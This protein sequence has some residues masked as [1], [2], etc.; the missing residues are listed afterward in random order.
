MTMHD[1]TSPP[2]I[3]SFCTV[4][5][6]LCVYMQAPADA[7]AGLVV[8]TGGT[9]YYISDHLTDIDDA[10]AAALSDGFSTGWLVR[11]SI[12]NDAFLDLTFLAAAATPSE[13]FGHGY[14]DPHYIIRSYSEL[15]DFAEHVKYRVSPSSGEAWQ[16]V[17]TTN[18]LD[19][20]AA[21]HWVLT[22]P[23]SVA[24]PEPNTFLCF[25]LVGLAFGGWRK[26]KSD[27]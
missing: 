14:V 24:V 4:A 6:M 12:E 13:V 15:T 19:S 10:A 7:L 18:F 17:R 27:S 5:V 1:L 2:L 9:D 21:G 25:C 8:T 20:T 11:A 26:L 23:S 22:R 16:G 3:R